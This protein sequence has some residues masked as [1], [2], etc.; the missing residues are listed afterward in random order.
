MGLDVVHVLSAERHYDEFKCVVCNCLTSLDS[1]ATSC[2]SSPICKS[3]LKATKDLDSCPSCKMNLEKLECLKTSQPL[4]HRVLSRVK[5][6]CTYRSRC[7]CRWVGDYKNLLSHLESNHRRKHRKDALNGNKLISTIG[8][9]EKEGL[10]CHEKKGAALEVSEESHLE[11]LSKNITNSDA[12]DVRAG[13]SSDI[14]RKQT[15]ATDASNSYYASVDN[16]NESN[17]NNSGETNRTNLAGLVV[18]ALDETLPKELSSEQLLPPPLPKKRSKDNV[19]LKERNV[20]DEQKHSSCQTM[21]FRND[22][23][24]NNTS[25]LTRARS[26]SGLS[27]TTYGKTQYR[28]C[29]ANS[30]R[31]TPSSYLHSRSPCRSR[32]SD[33]QNSVASALDVSCSP[34]MK[35]KATGGSALQ[36][37]KSCSQLHKSSSSYPIE[38]PL[39]EIVDNDGGMDDS[40]SRRAEAQLRVNNFEECIQSSLEAILANEGNVKV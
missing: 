22:D 14:A 7:K 29:K 11:P 36:K 27:N 1:F 25:I 30:L 9:V 33:R 26:E 21:S 10:K 39:H 12:C 5:V 19:S 3:C 38:N 24:T 6:R 15:P 35:F 4:A 34:L 32:L 16:D 18:S 20:F 28:S 2:C 13:S 23:V 8:N 17:A 31:K 40:F 37:E